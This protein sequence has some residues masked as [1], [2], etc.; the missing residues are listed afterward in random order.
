MRTAP[1]YQERLLPSWWAWLLMLSLVG[2]LAVAYGGAFGS[3][4]G[5]LT[6]AGGAILTVA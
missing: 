5:W 6:F 3:L 4:L 1:A 2:M